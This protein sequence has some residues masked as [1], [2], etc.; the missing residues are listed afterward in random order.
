MMLILSF[1]KILTHPFQYSDEEEETQCQWRGQANFCKMHII[2]ECSQFQKE[3]DGA[4][5]L[6]RTV[7]KN[8]LPTCINRGIP[9]AMEIR[10][11]LNQRQS[12]MIKNVTGMT[13]DELRGVE[14]RELRAAMK[15]KG[16]SARRAVGAINK[17][18]TEL[19]MPKLPKKQRNKGK[20]PDA[21]N[22]YSDGAVQC[23]AT[24]EFAIGGCG[25]WIP[26]RLKADM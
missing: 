4:S 19:T 3:R 11:G 7:P 18:G 15:E 8:T 13:G 17:G 22:A 2:W 14:A 16:M 1:N 20:A 5:E 12:E 10:E 26:G 25:I 21:I 23:P 9:P 6:L 24:Q